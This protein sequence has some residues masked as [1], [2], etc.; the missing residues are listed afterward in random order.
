MNLIEVPVE[1]LPI[2]AAQSRGYCWADNNAGHKGPDGV[3]THC[4]KPAREPLG[5]CSAC[6]LE[7]TGREL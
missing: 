5:L 7:I 1:D 4:G 6:H 3:T 2:F